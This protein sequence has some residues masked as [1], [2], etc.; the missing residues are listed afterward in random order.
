MPRLSV[1][2]TK[3]A[4]P[5]FMTTQ[6]HHA[7]PFC[8]IPNLGRSV[9]AAADELRPKNEADIKEGGGQADGLRGGTHPQTRIR[10][11]Y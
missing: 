5:V 10:S 3:D 6:R 11:K 1:G 7:N 2:Q 4:N 9:P 8:D